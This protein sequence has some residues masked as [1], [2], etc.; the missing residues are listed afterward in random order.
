MERVWG[1]RKAEPHSETA[2]SICNSRGSAGGAP[3]VG[4]DKAGGRKGGHARALLAGR[5]E[6]ASSRAMF[7]QLCRRNQEA[8]AQNERDM[9]RPT[10]GHV[11]LPTWGQTRFSNAVRAQEHDSQLSRPW[12]DAMAREQAL[13]GSCRACA[14]RERLRR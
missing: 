3:L 8:W 13:S 5:R 12:A 6:A 9:R 7:S 1:S 4:F 10:N 11:K 14:W 2:I